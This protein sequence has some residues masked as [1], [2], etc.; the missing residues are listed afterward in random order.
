MRMRVGSAGGRMTHTIPPHCVATPDVAGTAR[1]ATGGAA[2][3][4]DYQQA[5]AGRYDNLFVL[6]SKVVENAE[7]TTRLNGQVTQTSP[8]DM[9]EQMQNALSVKEPRECCALAQFEAYGRRIQTLV[10]DA[11]RNAPAGAQSTIAAL[12]SAMTTGNALFE[13]VQK[14]AN[15]QPGTP[16][17][18][19]T[20]LRLR[21]RKAPDVRSTRR[22][23]RRNITIGTHVGH[24]K[25]IYLI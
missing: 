14:L 18:V 9:L 8:T 7:K 20:S 24:T 21:H 1:I 11:A 13:T 5:A 25:K 22:P 2:I 4:L 17:V 10:E 16:G 23:G 15:R 6:A 12:N 3:M 19:G